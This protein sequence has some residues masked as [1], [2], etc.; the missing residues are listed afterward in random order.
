MG[1]S[2]G[3]TPVVTRRSVTDWLAASD[4]RV[5]LE[6][7]VLSPSRGILGNARG[8]GRHMVPARVNAVEPDE[9]AWAHL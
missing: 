7:S 5:D 8:R 2:P 4:E 1:V 3:H 6:G 9:T